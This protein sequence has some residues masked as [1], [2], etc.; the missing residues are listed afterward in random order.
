[1]KRTRLAAL[2]V[3][4]ALVAAACGGS[5]DDTTTTTAAPSDGT[6][7]AAPSGSSTTNT[8]TTAPPVTTAPPT[9]VEAGSGGELLLLQ[10]QAVTHLNP[11]TGTGTKDIQNISGGGLESGEWQCKKKSNVSDKGDV[12]N[13]YAAIYEHTSGDTILAMGIERAS[14]NGTSTP[15][16]SRDPSRLTRDTP[17]QT[18][19]GFSTMIR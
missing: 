11:Y 1:M 14:D 10:W 9:Q 17:R 5:S 19:A 6:T 7:T 18:P 13:A 4:L 8:P 16:G 2:F 3:V 15:S 12:L